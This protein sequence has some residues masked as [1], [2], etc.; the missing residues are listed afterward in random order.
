M[1]PGETPPP[2]PPLSPEVL[3]VLNKAKLIDT[4]LDSKDARGPLLKLVRGAFPDLRIP[5]LE[6]EAVVD[7]RVKATVD[8]VAQL[9]KELN[10]ERQDRAKE[11]RNA[12]A[13]RAGL[14]EGEI[15]E[16][17]KL[18]DDAGISNFETAVQHHKLTRAAAT[19][20][21]APTPIQLPSMKGLFQNPSKWSRD[22][23]FRYFAERGR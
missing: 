23:A 22:E 6:T 14:E 16:V 21:L 20:R 2:N 7:D 5:E 18:M 10:E 1:P 12:K 11:R 3:A 8:E 4:L 15:A 9:R 19:P 13:Q 17:E